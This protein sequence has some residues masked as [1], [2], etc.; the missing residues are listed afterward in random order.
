MFSLL[1]YRLKDVLTAATPP[2]GCEHISFSRRGQS[3]VV[4][5]MYLAHPL[6]LAYAIQKV[7]VHT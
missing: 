5:Q 1:A 2:S 4:N 3:N 6:A 7:C